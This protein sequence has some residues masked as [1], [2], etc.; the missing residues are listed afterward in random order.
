MPKA[1]EAQD[2]IRPFRALRLGVRVRREAH[3]DADAESWV[4]LHPQCSS[5]MTLFIPNGRDY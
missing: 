3:D 4:K 1:R 5:F 2:E